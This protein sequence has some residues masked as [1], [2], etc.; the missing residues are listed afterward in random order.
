[1][2][3]AAGVAVVSGSLV[4]SARPVAADIYLLR[5]KKGIL[6]IT[7]A[8]VDPGYQLV[9]RQPPRVARPN[10]L[11]VVDGRERGRARIVLPLVDPGLGPLAVLPRPLPIGPRRPMPPLL[12]GAPTPVV[13]MIRIIGER[14]NVQGS[15]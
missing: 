7:N 11:K 1:M 5:D 14:Y 13:Q 2:R 4:W 10:V 6:H 9:V 15:L 8:P 3:A 12:P